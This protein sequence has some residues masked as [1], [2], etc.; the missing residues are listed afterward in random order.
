MTDKIT[1]DRE[2]DWFVITDEETSVTT[3]G[4]SKNEALLMLADALA[5]YKESDEDLLS[6]ATDIFVPDPKMPTMQGPDGDDWSPDPPNESRVKK[7]RE[8]ALHLAKSHK[9]ADFSDSHFI[10]RISSM[11]HGSSYGT[12]PSRLAELGSKGY[13]GVFEKIASGTRSIDELVES[14]IDRGVAQEAVDELRRLGIVA[15]ADDG[16]LYAGYE[17][18]TTEPYLISSKNVIDWRENFNHVLVD[19]LDEDDLPETPEEGVF[20]ERMGTGYG[21]YHDPRTYNSTPSDVLMTLEEAEEKAS[22]PCPKC[23][24]ESEGA[25]RFDV[26]DM[27]GGV[28]R[29]E[30]K[31]PDEEDNR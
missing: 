1:I 15:E 24:P 12:K 7:N 21:W 26:T 10:H 5:A 28:T 9:R 27:P 25:E 2:D 8:L 4:K 31:D 16:E 29:Y 19:D 18:I 17:V 11:I 14:G 23:F 30:A 3:Q 6:M 13:W 20:V 22:M